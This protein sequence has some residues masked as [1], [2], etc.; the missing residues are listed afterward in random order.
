MTFLWVLSLLGAVVG[1]LVLMVGVIG[2]SGAPQEAAAAGIACALAVIPYCFARAIE[3]LNSPSE[4]MFEETRTQ[5]KLLAALANKAHEGE[6][7]RT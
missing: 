2:S 4:K 1:G 6:I 5:T 3:K 7:G